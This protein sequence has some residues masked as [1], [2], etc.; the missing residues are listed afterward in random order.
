MTIAEL[1]IVGAALVI[2]VRLL[3]FRRRGKRIRRG[4]SV[5]AW[6][7][8]SASAWIIARTV[9]EGHPDAWWF[10]LL[11]VAIATLVLRADGNL[12]HLFHPHRRL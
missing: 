6:M 10:A 5:L 7:L 3:T 4:V 11:M 12:A 9:T 1:V 8:I 2:I